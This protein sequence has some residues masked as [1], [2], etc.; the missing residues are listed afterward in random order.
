FYYRDGDRIAAV[1]RRIM[2]RL[3]GHLSEEVLTI[4]TGTT[5]SVFIGLVGTAAA[6]AVVAFIG[7]VISGVPGAFMLAVATFV[8]S[9]VP[10]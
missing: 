7:F 4:V 1:T 9:V 3:S 8:L 6:Q 10:M 2:D 5:R